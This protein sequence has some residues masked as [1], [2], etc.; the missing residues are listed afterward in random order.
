MN[1][2]EPYEDVVDVGSQIDQLQS[3]LRQERRANIETERLLKLAA[4]RE[5]EACAEIADKL[6]DDL[7]EILKGKWREETREFIKAQGL[8][9]NKIAKRIRCRK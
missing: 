5:R 3:E 7:A 6:A 2:D 9:A 1:F 4:E 8:A